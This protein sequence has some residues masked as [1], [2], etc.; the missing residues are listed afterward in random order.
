MI[1]DTL[2]GLVLFAAS[3]GPGYVYLRVAERR[4]PQPA[5]SS[6]IEAVG[7]LVIG[8]LASTVAGVVVLTAGDGLGLIEPGRVV[9]DF[10][11][12]VGDKPLRGLVLVALFA[13]AYGGAALAAR[14]IHRKRPAVVSPGATVWDKIFVEKAPSKDHVAFLTVELKDGRRFAGPMKYCTVEE[15]DN[16]ELGLLSPIYSQADARSKPVLTRDEF[17]VIR[18]QETVFVAGRYWKFR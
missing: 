16:R 11:A 4:R 8:A 15:G 9:D 18:E 17:M 5:R 13:L 12:Y 2:L 10:E 6:L 7:L 3:L 14:L 1:P